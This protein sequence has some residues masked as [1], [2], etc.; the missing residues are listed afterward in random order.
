MKALACG[1]VPV[2]YNTRKEGPFFVP[3][4]CNASS[5]ENRMD[6]QTRAIMTGTMVGMFVLATQAQAAEIFAGRRVASFN[7]DWKF[8]K[9]A[10]A[11]AENPAF[12]DSAW[13]PVRL[14]HDWA[15]VRPLQSER[16]RLCRQ[17]A[18]EAATA[19]TANLHARPRRQR[20]T[21]LPRLRRRDGLPQDLHQRQARRPVGLRLHVLPRRRHRISLNS[22]N[23][24]SSRSG[25]HPQAGHPLVSRR[26]HLSQSDL[27]GLRRRCT[28]PTGAR[29]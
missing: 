3:G 27:D 5:E 26:R 9:G 19:G 6:R 16:T 17:A 12:D 13:Q 20:Q 1:I 10:Q 29:S 7:A 15:I 8:A 21:R 14:P 28:S 25:R 23:P 11:G 18:L 4:F 24:T 2:R 22:A